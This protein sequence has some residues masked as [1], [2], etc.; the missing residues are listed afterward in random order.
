MINTI[1]FS[2]AYDHAP[3]V[4]SRG[5]SVAALLELVAREPRPNWS[6]G[7]VEAALSFAYEM[8][9]VG[10]SRRVIGWGNVQGQD[11]Q[12]HA[13]L[14]LDRGGSVLT[15]CNGRWSRTETWSLAPGVG[16]RIAPKCGAC[17]SDELVLKQLVDDG[18][19]VPAKT[20]AK[21]A[22]RA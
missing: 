3:Q 9:R 19:I 4:E 16:A 8:A 7:A 2:P 14:S 13:I 1:L 18:V 12:W 10:A 22:R 17:E 11:S 6:L 21:I 15:G 5:F 20:A